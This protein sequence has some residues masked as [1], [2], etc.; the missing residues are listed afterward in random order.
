MEQTGHRVAAQVGFALAWLPSLIET[1]RNA[2]TELELIMADSEPSKKHSPQKC[3]N[4]G[5]EGRTA[6]TCTKGG[7]THVRSDT[8]PPTTTL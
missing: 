2:E 8:L 7:S 1:I 3:S 6:R 5:A 4:C